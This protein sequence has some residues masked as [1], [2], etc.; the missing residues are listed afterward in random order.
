M[1]LD[2]SKFKP[3]IISGKNKVGDP[4]ITDLSKGI[5]YPNVHSAI[6]QI[7]NMCLPIGAI[8]MTVDNI[9]PSGISIT[10]RL[11][12]ELP[13]QSIK[14]PG[15]VNLYGLSIEL[16]LGDTIDIVT[17]KIFDSLNR[18]VTENLGL[19]NISRPLGER[20]KIDVTFIDR[21]NHNNVSVNDIILGI[22]IK[23]STISNSQNGYGQWEKIGNNNTLIP[24]TDIQ[25]W[26]RL[27]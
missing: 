22:V 20:G 21:L 2:N 9:D 24:G 15:F 11:A 27:A 13:D 4:T 7:E 17:S 26:R 14:N 23:G 18:L 6:S 12:I 25:I 16:S 3:Q 1:N 10:E 8:C 5:D 19:D